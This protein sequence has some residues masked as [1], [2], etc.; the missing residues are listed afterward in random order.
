MVMLSNTKFL[1]SNQ[2][3]LPSLMAEDLVLIQQFVAVRLWSGPFEVLG[4]IASSPVLM[5]HLVINVLLE[6][7]MSI[8]SLFGQLKFPCIE[9][10][11][12]DV[13]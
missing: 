12:T 1:K 2:L 11:S 9:T 10:S 8:P 13:F 7:S 3:A 5:L 4:Q 6:S